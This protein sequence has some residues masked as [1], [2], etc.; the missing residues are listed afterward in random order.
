MVHAADACVLS[1]AVDGF[2][3]NAS[4]IHDSIGTSPC[5]DLDHLLERANESIYQTA[6]GYLE[7]ILE[8][9]GVISGQSYP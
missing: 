7:A 8:A 2:E 6:N 9:N 1:Y 4:L 5:A 3:G